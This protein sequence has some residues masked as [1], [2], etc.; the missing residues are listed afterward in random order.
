M[1]QTVLLTVDATKVPY[2]FGMP[3]P[4]LSNGSE[5]C[6]PIIIR[7]GVHLYEGFVLW[8]IFGGLDVGVVGKCDTPRN[9]FLEC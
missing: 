4:S 6:Y 7:R 3:Q 1:S 8:P 2:Y 5:L 9:C